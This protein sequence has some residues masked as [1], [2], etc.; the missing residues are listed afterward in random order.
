MHC[1]QCLR[2]CAGPWPRLAANSGGRG[3][4][5]KGQATAGESAASGHAKRRFCPGGCRPSDSAP[6]FFSAGIGLVVVVRKLSGI[7][8]T[9][10]PDTRP[11][12]PGCSSP[13]WARRSCFWRA[14]LTLCLGKLFLRSRNQSVG[15]DENRNQTP[16]GSIHMAR[17]PDF[18]NCHRKFI[19][20][21][22]YRSSRAWKS[23][24]GPK[25][26]QQKID[27]RMMHRILG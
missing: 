6:R 2:N 5:S 20:D 8:C 11:G 21:S 12:G 22:E 23:T 9:G 13:C 16:F 26:K 15:P 27:P 1:N 19:E 14:V 17:I 18:C 4:P 24:E 25:A 3:P 10:R 7:F